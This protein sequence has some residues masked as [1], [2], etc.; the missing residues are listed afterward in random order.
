MYNNNVLF[1]T[2]LNRNQRDIKW[3]TS[4][5]ST[6]AWIVMAN[7]GQVLK[8]QV[9]GFDFKKPG[10]PGRVL[11]FQNC[12][13]L[14]NLD[15]KIDTFCQITKLVL[16]ISPKYGNFKLFSEFLNILPQSEIFLINQFDKHHTQ[17]IKSPKLIFRWLH[18][19]I[20]QPAGPFLKTIVQKY[21]K[22][23]ILGSH[24]LKGFHFLSFSHFLSRFLSLFLS[25]PSGNSGIE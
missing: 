14:A 19:T 4:I 23:V 18:I 2:Y 5:T 24:A 16:F 20:F 8:K 25:L 22:L 7:L 13:N 9:S 17:Y 15:W 12:T 6:T 1:H 10:Y 21:L 11:G 3:D